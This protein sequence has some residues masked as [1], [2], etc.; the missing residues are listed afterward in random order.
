M[1]ITVRSCFAANNS[2]RAQLSHLFRAQTQTRAIKVQKFCD[3]LLKNLK[4][5]A[6]IFLL[7]VEPFGKSVDVFVLKQLITGESGFY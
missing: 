7:N 1:R 5:K 6:R 4:K 2:A 3:F